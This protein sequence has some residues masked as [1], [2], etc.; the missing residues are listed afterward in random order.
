MTRKEKNHKKRLK[1]KGM[2]G[3]C[4]NFAGVKPIEKKELK[5]LR[6]DEIIEL[7]QY[8]YEKMSDKKREKLREYVQSH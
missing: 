8:V 6:T 7:G 2:Y 1:A 3:L 4:C 5:K